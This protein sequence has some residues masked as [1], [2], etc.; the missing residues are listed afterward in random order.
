M[1]PVKIKEQFEAAEQYCFDCPVAIE[2]LKIS[3]LGCETEGVWGGTTEPERK[4]LLDLTYDLINPRQSW[5]DSMAEII[6]DIAVN[7]VTGKRV[8]RTEVAVEL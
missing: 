6:S 4:I 8:A 5:D 7:Y 1:Y 2:C 3:L